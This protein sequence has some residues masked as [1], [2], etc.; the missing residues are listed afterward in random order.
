MGIGFCS[1]LCPF[2]ANAT[3]RTLR[4]HT[5]LSDGCSTGPFRQSGV[6]LMN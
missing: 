4:Q 3:G 6:S 2:D 1:E 5:E